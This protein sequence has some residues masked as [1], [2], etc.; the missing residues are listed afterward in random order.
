MGALA[1]GTWT[2]KFR[3]SLNKP[4]T[5]S[6]K[7]APGAGVPGSITKEGGKALQMNLACSG[8]RLTPLVYTQLTLTWPSLIQNF[9]LT[10]VKWK[11]PVSH[12]WTTSQVITL[13]QNSIASLKPDQ[14]SL[15]FVNCTSYS[16]ISQFQKKEMTIDSDQ[17]FWGENLIRNIS[18]SKSII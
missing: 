8:P 3:S 12:L 10:L 1:K 15:C 9:C 18:N 17:R 4:D 14:I 16:L 7:R 2:V 6:L 13:F 5:G 11:F